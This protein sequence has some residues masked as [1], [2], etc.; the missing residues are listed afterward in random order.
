MFTYNGESI[1]RWEGDTLVVET[2]YIETYNHY[3]DTGHSDLRGVQVVE[4]IRLLEDGE[5]LEI[6]Y[7]MTD[8]ELGRRVA[9]HEALVAAGSHRHRR[10]RCLPDLNDNMPSTQAGKSGRTQK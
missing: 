3:I 5:V 6:E 8:P 2:Q 9:Q 1:G 4:R 10:G 7:I